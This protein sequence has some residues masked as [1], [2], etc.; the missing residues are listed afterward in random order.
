MNLALFR[1]NKQVSAE[2]AHYF[3]SANTFILLEHHQAHTVD[4]GDLTQSPVYC[5]YVSRLPT[6]S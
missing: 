6:L 5:W 3:Y 4:G 1:V 2:A